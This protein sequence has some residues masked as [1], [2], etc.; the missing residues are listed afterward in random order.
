MEKISDRVTVMD[1]DPKKKHKIKFICKNSDN[2]YP[3]N[4]LNDLKVLKIK[5]KKYELGEE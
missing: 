1:L 4:F 5:I 3:L 2:E